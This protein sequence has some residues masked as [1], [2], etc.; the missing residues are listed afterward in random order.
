MRI[1]KMPAKIPAQWQLSRRTALLRTDHFKSLRVV[2]ASQVAMP[3][4]KWIQR[5]PFIA[6]ALAAAGGVI[7]ETITPEI[8]SATI[9]Y[10]VGVLVGYWLPQPKA[11]LALA[12]LA[13]PLIIIGDWIS[14]P[15]GPS[16]WKVLLNRSL[17]VGVVWLGAVKD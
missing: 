13:T 15:N 1:E 3:D 8:I 4:R 14:I 11:A 12:L 10:V 7:F 16:D 9:F 2:K 17:A 6:V 5:A